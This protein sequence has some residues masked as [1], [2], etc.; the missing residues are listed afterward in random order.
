MEAPWEDVP[1]GTFSKT[2]DPVV[3]P[4]EHAQIAEWLQ[5]MAENAHISVPETRQL[6][7]A[8]DATEWY[9]A[10]AAACRAAHEQFEGSRL[11]LLELVGELS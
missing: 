2:Y 1:R 6:L 5:L 7:N 9:E 8:L 10:E 4:N 11:R 3:N